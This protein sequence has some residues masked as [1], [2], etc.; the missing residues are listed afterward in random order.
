M[1]TFDT[2]STLA[3]TS[4]VSVVS[5]AGTSL[6]VNVQTGTGA[7]FAINQQVLVSPP[8]A[9]ASIG[10]TMIC[11][12]TGIS[13]DQLTL[14]TGVSVREGSGLRLAQIGD[15]IANGMTPKAL[16]D[17]E[18]ATQE[19][20]SNPFTT[21]NL[22]TITNYTWTSVHAA[23]TLPGSPSTITT[24]FTQPDV[25]RSI[26]A[27]SIGA[28]YSSTTVTVHGTDDTN[29]VISD[30]ILW[31][32]NG[33]P[34]VGM[35]FKTFKTI[36][37]IDIP[38]SLNPGDTIAF[39]LGIYL[40][41]GRLFTMNAWGFPLIAGGVAP[42]NTQVITATQNGATSVFLL[43]VNINDDPGAG[44]TTTFSISIITN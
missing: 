29:A 23:V 1:P 28:D 19:G 37:S 6:I 31:A 7:L 11:R 27:K 25:T 42:S 8:N 44:T 12:L 14:N 2:H 10:N 22:G 20:G 38:A 32:Y 3:A 43:T 36:T 35:T 21:V 39:G 41:M 40:S 30:T 18:A 5:Q 9:Q 33:D 26:I 17:I 16:T 13:G 24:G 15:S 4:I 34:S